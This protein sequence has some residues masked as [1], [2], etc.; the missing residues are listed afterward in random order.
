M[1]I[2]CIS[3]SAVPSS[4]ANSIQAMK[5]C[6]ALAQLGHEVTLLVP[7]PE[8]PAVS[9]AIFEE[10]GPRRRG[11]HLAEKQERGL[12]SFYGLSTSFPVEWLPGSSRRA[13]TWRSVRRATKLGADVVYTWVPQSAVFALLHRLPAVL[14]LHDL[15]AGRVG[16][17]WYRL[18]LRLP[19][20]KRI[21]VI[22]RALIAALDDAY[23]VHVASADVILTPNGV[24]A[25]RFDDLPTPDQARSLTGL[26][27]AP[28]VLCA[29][30]LYSGRGADLF[31]DLAGSLPEARFVW[32]G[33]SPDDVDAWRARASARGLANV[34]FLGFIPNEKVPLY[35]AAADVLLMPYARNIGISSGGGNS[36][37]ISSPMK[38]FEYLAAGRAILA[39]DLPVFRE[40]LNERNAVL[41]PPEDG[42]AWAAALRDLLHNAKKREGLS[43]QARTDSARYTWVERARRALD[44]FLD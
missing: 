4:T 3:A 22:T 9:P 38:M 19:G 15:P 11:A 44:G 34:T 17:L 10:Y 21:M 37:I 35:L 1:K 23:G 25:E 6:Q 20:R 33:G 2:V 43:A 8:L 36:G 14:E 39:S 28:T 30:H 27:E 31:L 40:V 32:A 24:E 13:F 7:G 5:A 42:A 16:P 29:G 26:P 41:C 12:L 18:F